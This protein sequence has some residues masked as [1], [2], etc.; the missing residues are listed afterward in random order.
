VRPWADNLWKV[1]PIYDWSTADVWTYPKQF[2]LDYNRAY[3]AMEMAGVSRNAQRCA[4]PYGEEPMQNLW[5]YSV[6]FPDIWDKMSNRVPGS[7]TAA[8][9]STTELYAFSALPSK[10]GNFTWPNWVRY[11]IA[12][13]P[14]P[15]RSQIAS[16]VQNWVRNHYGKTSDPIAPTVPHP[17]TGVSWRFLLMIAMRGD[18]KGRKQPVRPFRQEA[19]MKKAWEHYRKE[20]A[21]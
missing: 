11:W 21:T 10:P 14:Q 5:M 7:A 13:H 18:Y 20:L 8:R 3:D 1:Y 4:P 6:C 9:Y 2:K 16:R 15:Y 17:D 19:E 12:K